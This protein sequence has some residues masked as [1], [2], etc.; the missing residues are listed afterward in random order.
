MGGRTDVERGWFNLFVAAPGGRR[1][2]L[3]RLWITDPAGTPV[4]LVGFKDIGDDPG[5]DVWSDTTTLYVRLLKGHVPPPDG[6]AVIETTSAG[7]DVIA[8]GRM[9]IAPL[10]FARQLTTFRAV[11]PGGARAIAAFGALF[12]GEL[13]RVYVARGRVGNRR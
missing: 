5:F 4:T 1:R 7:D 12:L 3:Y 13:W 9:L 8:A 10:D 6:D 2:M 11:G